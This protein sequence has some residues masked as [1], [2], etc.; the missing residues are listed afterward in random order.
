[1]GF[2]EEF[3]KAQKAKKEIAEDLRIHEEGLKGRR[4]HDLALTAQLVEAGKVVAADAVGL[5]IPFDVIATETAQVRGAGVVSR[6]IP[7]TE[8]RVA[9]G[10]WVI[11]YRKVF[12][13]PDRLGGPVGEVWLL[14]QDGTFRHHRLTWAYH[15]ESFPERTEPVQISADAE[16][17]ILS[18]EYVS[19]QPLEPSIYDYEWPKQ[20]PLA[21]LVEHLAAKAAHWEI[22]PARI[23][24]IFDK[25]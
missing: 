24:P 23:M 1:M 12:R 11:Y 3:D 4:R 7:R 19:Q 8:R 18:V 9:F 15:G 5:R 13:N 10:A 22:D 6:W 2:R 16:L 14:C 17:P 25:G 20:W 21:E